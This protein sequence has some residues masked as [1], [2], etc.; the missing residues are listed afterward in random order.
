MRKFPLLIVASLC[1]APPA[2]AQV[3][4]DLHALDG[5]PAAKP[6]P[7]RMAPPAQPR[8]KVTL[9]PT[10]PAQPAMRTPP[11]AAPAAAEAVALPDVPPPVAPAPLAAPP[12]A[13]T[14]KPATASIRIPFAADQSELD[15]DGTAAI[16]GLIETAYTN[17]TPSFT[18]IA[19]AAGKPDDPSSARRL[20]LARA[21][22]ARDTLLSNGVPSR[23]I[24]VRALVSQAGGGPPDRVDI[25]TGPGISP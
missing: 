3:T 13:E 11:P 14:P 6:S 18:V 19:Y 25:S 20:S 24:N 10:A 21:T 8:P 4:V 9:T 22:A 23:R 12:A 7:F 5:L 15:K 16:Q 1:A 2:G 17:G